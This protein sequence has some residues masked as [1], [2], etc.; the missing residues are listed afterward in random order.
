MIFQRDN[1]YSQS[2]LHQAIANSPSLEPTFAS[3][4]HIIGRKSVILAALFLFTTGTIIASVAKTIGTLLVGRCFQGVGGG[5]LVGLTYVLLA[6]LVSLRERG[7]WMSIISLQ[8]AIGSVLGPVIGGAFAVR[9]WRWIFW[10]NIPFCALAAVGIPICLKLH[11][12]NG[13]VWARLKTFDWFGSFIFIAATTS[14]LIPITWVCSLKHV[15][16]NYANFRRVVWISNGHLGGL[17]S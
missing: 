15:L 3:F 4:S 2:I 8:W 6:D 7:K 9:T 10:L 5:G 1:A 16:D 17:L 13:S 14:F 12:R 11:P